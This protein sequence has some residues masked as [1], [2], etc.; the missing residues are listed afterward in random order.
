MRLTS[1]I[2]TSSDITKTTTS[3]CCTQMA[4]FPCALPSPGLRRSIPRE[5]LPAGADLR[6]LQPRLHFRCSSSQPFCAT[7][8]LFLLVSERGPS[9]SMQSLLIL[10]IERGKNFSWDLHLEHY[11]ISLLPFRDKRLKVDYTCSPSSSPCLFNITN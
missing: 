3:S 1:G 2:P 5:C 8:F 6:P 4:A 9:S 7:S 11:V 10:V